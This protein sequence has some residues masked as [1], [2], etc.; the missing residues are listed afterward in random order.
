MA[1]FHGSATSLQAGDH[2]FPGDDLGVSYYGRS[3][4]VYMTHSDFS[5]SEAED[6]T[7]GVRTSQQYALRSALLWACW[8]ADLT[9]DHNCPWAPDHADALTATIV[10][11][12]IH[13]YAVE[14]VGPVFTDDANDAGVDACR[15]ESAV[16]THVYD[17]RTIAQILEW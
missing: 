16:I 5:L 4:H 10:P 1:F 17:E 14:P 12:C 7:P 3:E 13:V 9:C 15:A 11:S 2:L 8:A 6:V